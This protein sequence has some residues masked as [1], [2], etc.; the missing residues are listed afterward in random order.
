LPLEECR[1]G[2]K[3]TQLA[4][5]EAVMSDMNDAPQLQMVWPSSRL[6][7]PPPVVLPPGYRLRPYQPGDETRFFE[8]MA[9]AGWPGW[10]EERLKPWLYRM[11]P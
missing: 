3:V 6:S 10:D 9:L 11:L 2:Q 4:K 5:R 7:Q 1:S 8:V